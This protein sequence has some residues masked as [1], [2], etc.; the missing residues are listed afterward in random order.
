MLAAE[1]RQ[2]VLAAEKFVFAFA[3]RRQRIEADQHIVHE[4][5]MA[6]DDSG[7][8]HPLKELAHQGAEIG[9]PGKIIGAGKSGVEGNAGAGGAAA[10]L[11]AQHVEN[12]RL[13]RIQTL[14]QRPVAAALAN[15]C[16][17]C[18]FLDRRQES[19]AHARKELRMLVAIDKVGAAAEQ[20]DEGCELHRQFGLDEF[21]S[22]VFPSDRGGAV[23]V[24]GKNMPPSMGRKCMVSGR[25]GAVRVT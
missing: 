4:A 22:R 9:L 24:C 17:G 19:L 8:R 3:L 21:G 18:C 10:E 13:R 15:P 7:L 6:H 1:Q 5:R 16:V 25:N 20:L 2:K 23:S 12:Q 14:R 11:R